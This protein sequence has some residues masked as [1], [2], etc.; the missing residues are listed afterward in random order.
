[1][2]LGHGEFQE[3]LQRPNLVV[4]LLPAIGTI[5]QQ[6]QSPHVAA[7]RPCV[8]PEVGTRTQLLEF[9]DF[10]TRSIDVKDAPLGC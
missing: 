8:I 10:L 2:F 6:G 9:A 1:I 4:E 7:S 3:I 5:F